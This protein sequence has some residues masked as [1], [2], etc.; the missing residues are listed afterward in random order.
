VSTHDLPTF[1]GYWEGRDWTVRQ[2]IGVI[3]DEEAAHAL[4]ER[5]AARERLFAA[6]ARAGAVPQD[7]TAASAAVATL[8]DA[9]HRFLAGSSAQ[10]FL[11]Q[12]DDMFGEREQINVPGTTTAYPNWRRRLSLALEAPECAAALH[13]LA[14]ICAAA[15]R[16]HRPPVARPQSEGTGAASQ[17]SSA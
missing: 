8:C 1:A 3:S 9:A 17:T 2:R 7:E 15:V 10:L 16:C 6:F 14:E 11:A 4:A 13:R 12:L 5:A